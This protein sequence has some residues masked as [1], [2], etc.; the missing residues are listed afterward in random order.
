MRDWARS[1][2][3]SRCRPGAG[4]R[5]LHRD[6]AD[7]ARRG[8][9]DD[10]LASCRGATVFTE[11]YAARGATYRQPATSQERA[12]GFAVT[13][14]TGTL[15]N[16]AWLA[17]W[18]V[19]PHAAS[20]TAKPCA[21]GPSSATTPARS[22]PSPDGKV[23]GQ[24]SWR[25]PS[26]IPISPGLI[27]AAFIS[28]STS[29]APGEGRSTSRTSSTSGPPYRSNLTAFTA[30]SWGR[31]RR[32][33]RE[34]SGVRGKPTAVAQPCRPATDAP[35]RRGALRARAARSR[36]ARRCQPPRPARRSNTVAAG[37]AAKLLNSRP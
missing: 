1:R 11:A 36:A 12:S 3:R 20:P 14:V 10:D 22:L 32:L 19:Q 26:R 9:D 2:G 8:R 33:P 6:A 5:E 7:P 31:G 16:S 13:C 27:A 28:T 4:R 29:P 23:A 24:S 17:R 21:P 34:R 37:L 15:T 18:S 25:K 30:S 35:I